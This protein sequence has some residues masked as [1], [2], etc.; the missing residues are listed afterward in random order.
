MKV[1]IKEIKKDY[2]NIIFKTSDN[3][4][5]QVLEKSEIRQIIQDLD[6]AI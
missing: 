4:I 3:E 5:I 6:N 2:Y 1:K